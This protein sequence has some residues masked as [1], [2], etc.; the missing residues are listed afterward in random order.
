[1]IKIKK[2]LDLP[3]TGAPEQAIKDTKT[4]TQVAI[5]GDDYVGMKPT[6]EIEEGDQVKLGQVL[7]SDKKTD[8]VKY[9][10]PGAGKVVAINRGAKRKLLSVV[11]ELSGDDAETFAKYPADQLSSLSREQVVE[12]LASSGQWT[13]F[14][15]RP[16]SKVP[17]LDAV[18]DAIFVTAIDTHPLAAD[19]ALV[20]KENND[21]FNQGLSLLT[22]LTNGKVHVCTAANQDFII[23][24]NDQINH[25]TFGGCHPAG[26]PGT[27]IHFLHGASSDHP[28]WHIGYQDV[29]AIAKLFTEG[30]LFTDRVIAIGGPSATQPRLI[31][32]RL[33]ASLKELLQGEVAAGDVRAI[34]GSVF[35]GFAA[36]GARAFLGRF[37]NQVSLLPEGREKEF[38][39]WIHA[40]KDKYSVTRSFISH[41]MP[42]KKF[43]FTT[44]TGG[45]ERAIMP[46]GSYERIMPLDILATQLL[47]ALVSNDTDTAQQLG[48]LELDEEDLALATYVCP[49]KFEYGPIL[50]NALTTIEKEG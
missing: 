30:K 14:R 31:R 17:A 3:I 42:G 15:T 18:P 46:I 4:V 20:I 43:D 10:A 47:R 1:M 48:C 23:A 13:A 7:F 32:T 11:I 19:P 8:G 21:A 41:L 6:M 44:T 25:Q 24:G 50:R 28:V 35:S 5:L 27:H 49:G 38:F 22:R 40:G 45:S 37:H 34:S 12:N 29:I 36:T 16:Y 2:G 39:G 9:T 26:L 33:G